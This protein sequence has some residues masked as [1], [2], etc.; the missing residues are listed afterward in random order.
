MS[1]STVAK[2][3]EERFS[4]E[5]RPIAGCSAKTFSQRLEEQ[6]VASE[7]RESPTGQSDSIKPIADVT[8]QNQLKDRTRDD[9][10]EQYD[11]HEGPPPG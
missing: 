10:G 9:Y 3:L 4:R 7:E 5:H 6:G 1:L 2:G 8:F 11:H